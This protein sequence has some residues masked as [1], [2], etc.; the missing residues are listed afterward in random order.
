MGRFPFR[1]KHVVFLAFLLVTASGCGGLQVGVRVDDSLRDI[2]TEVH[3][4]GVTEEEYQKWAHYSM[5]KYFSP[6]DGLRESATSLGY[7]Y[8]MKFGAGHPALQRPSVRDSLTWRRVQER[9]SQRGAKYLFVLADLAG[10]SDRPGEQ[11]PRRLILQNPWP[12]W[13]FLFPRN[14]HVLI[15]RGGLMRTTAPSGG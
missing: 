3:L 2:S 9:W 15:T 13:S 8:V 1:T 6:G 4:V 7:S 11:D 14:I 10:F 12:W 5:S